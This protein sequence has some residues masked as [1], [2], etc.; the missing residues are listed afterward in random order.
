[1]IIFVIF[2]TSNVPPEY[3]GVWQTSVRQHAKHLQA[4]CVRIMTKLFILFMNTN[5]IVIE[6]SPYITL[7]RGVRCESTCVQRACISFTR[8]TLSFKCIT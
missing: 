2:I 4:Y 6:I 1:M 3:Y 8:L 7:R 5:I